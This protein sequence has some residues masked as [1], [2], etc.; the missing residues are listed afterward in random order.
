MAGLTYSA[1]DLGVSR[2]RFLGVWG[3]AQ[4]KLPSYPPKILT[5]PGIGLH[6]GLIPLIFEERGGP[7]LMEGKVQVEITYCVG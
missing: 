5:C 6:Y 1:L 7:T 4:E 3:A 2:R